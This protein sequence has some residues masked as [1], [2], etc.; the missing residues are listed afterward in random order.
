MAM[1]AVTA[2]IVTMMFKRM[3]ILSLNNAVDSASVRHLIAP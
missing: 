2:S 1:A 3:G